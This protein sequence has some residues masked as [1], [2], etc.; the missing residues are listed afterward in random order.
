VIQITGTQ[1]SMRTG[2]G[3]MPSTRA[4]IRAGDP[5]AFGQ[6][7]DENAR[8][9]YRHALR[10]TADQ[11]TAEDVLSLTFLEAWRLRERLDP[12]GDR[13][14]RPEANSDPDGLRAWLFG[15]ALNVLRNTSRAAR[16]HRAALAR[17]PR[18]S[19]TPDPADT[20]IDRM[21]DAG[22]LVAAKQALER[23]RPDEREVIAMC[24][25]SEVDY[26]TAAGVLGIPVGT[27]RSRLSRAKA[28]LR[29]L[30][31]RP[32]SE[33]DPHHRSFREPALTRGQGS[34]GST[35][36]ARSGQERKR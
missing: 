21:A 33:S 3:V 25:W 2:T 12:E 15:I 13:P 9:I 31:G 7:F 32:A 24:V 1:R 26:A 6:L 14:Q 16:R 10:V 34:G 28:K 5:D 8:A 30:V 18:P 20:V 11:S 29:R 4:R 36:A 17:M 35:I 23:L 27:V 19:P 22:D